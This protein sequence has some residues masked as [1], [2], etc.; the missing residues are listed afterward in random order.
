MHDTGT[1]NAKRIWHHEENKTRTRRDHS[2]MPE[3]STY[4]ALP[5]TR[6]LLTFLRS[7]PLRIWLSKL[8]GLDGLL[9][10]GL[11]VTAPVLKDVEG[12]V[13]GGA[14]ARV[15]VGAGRSEVK[16]GAGAGCRL[17]VGSVGRV[18]SG[19]GRVEAEAPDELISS[20]VAGLDADQ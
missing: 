16:V 20:Y 14:G 7:V 19:L 15:G 12:G 18:G 3:N 13:A 6:L 1:G 11:G 10:E 8:D 4:D 17:A 5:C 2:N 9:T